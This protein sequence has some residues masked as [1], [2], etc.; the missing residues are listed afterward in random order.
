MATDNIGLTEELK[1]E[2]VEARPVK[3]D[4][5]VALIRSLD[6]IALSRVAVAVHKTLHEV[7]EQ[8]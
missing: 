7:R 2:L 4:D 8:G 5:L 1:V 6:E 3:V